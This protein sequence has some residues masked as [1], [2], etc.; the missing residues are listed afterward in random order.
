M[1]FEI[2]F[3]HMPNYALIRTSGKASV[4]GIV[5]MLTELIDSP[6]WKTG[7]NQLIDHRKLI[8]HKFTSDDMRKLRDIIQKKSKKL[9]NGRCAFVVRDALGFGLA[10]MYEFLGGEDIHQEVDVFYT[11]NEAIDFFSLKDVIE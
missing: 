11:I 1:K 8:L 2:N 3:D 7:T 9:G 6:C 5:K 4:H 10:R